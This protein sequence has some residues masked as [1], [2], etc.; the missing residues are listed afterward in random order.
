GTIIILVLGATVFYLN[1]K[2]VIHQPI[3]LY[4]LLVSYFIVFIPG[5]IVKIFLS[6]M[7]SIKLSRVVFVHE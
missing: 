1:L 5:D 7:T 2:F 6:S 4:T 3:S